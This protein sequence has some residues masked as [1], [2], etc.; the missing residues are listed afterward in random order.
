MNEIDKEKGKTER[1]NYLEKLKEEFLELQKVI[2]KELKADEVNAERV[3]MLIRSQ[4]EVYQR[5]L[6]ETRALSGDSPYLK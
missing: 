4:N 2:M 3:A 6:Q 1:T 5:V